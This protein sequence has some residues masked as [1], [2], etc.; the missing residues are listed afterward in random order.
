VGGGG[1][2]Q[3][4][5]SSSDIRREERDTRAG[6]M[7]SEREGPPVQVSCGW[8]TEISE[9]SSRTGPYRGWHRCLK[10]QGGIRGD[11]NGVLVPTRKVTVTQHAEVVRPSGFRMGGEKR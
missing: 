10:T 3:R 1:H 9:A 5:D 7:R 6:G 2:G 4:R 8:V 11:E